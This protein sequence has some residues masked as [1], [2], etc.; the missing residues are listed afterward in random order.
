MLISEVSSSPLSHPHIV[1]SRAAL[2]CLIPAETFLEQL[3]T[4][5]YSQFLSRAALH[6]LVPSVSFLEQLST[7]SYPQDLS[8]AALHCLVPTMSFLEQLSTVSYPQVLSRD[9]SPLSCLHIVLSRAAPH[10][11]GCCRCCRCCGCCRYDR[12]QNFYVH[13]QI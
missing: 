1:L 9:S 4:V 3:T 13:H 5:S 7:V 10:C 12:V 11:W 8:R 2:H 6:C